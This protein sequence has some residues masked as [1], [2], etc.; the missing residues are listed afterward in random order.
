MDQPFWCDKKIVG[1]NALGVPGCGVPQPDLASALGGKPS[2]FV[3]S[4]N[5][6]WRFLFCPS[7]GRCPEGFEQPAF[8]DENFDTIP[9]PSDWQLE[10][11]DTPIY[12]NIR[13]PFPISTDKKEL[14]K[15]DPARNP[16]GI[17][18][19]R[20]SLP[21]GFAGR[22]IFLQLDGANSAAEVF[23]NGQRAGFCLSSFDPHRFDLTDLVREGENLLA[24]R[25]FRWSTGSYLEDQDMWRL[26]GLFR[27]VLL[28]AEPQTGMRDLT[29][30]TLF[31][32]G[33]DRATLALTVALPDQLPSGCSLQLA[34]FAPDGT[35]AL[36]QTLRPSGGVQEF[37]FDLDRPLLWSDE[38]PHLYR[39]ALAL[40]RGEKILD[41][42]GLSVGFREVR[43]EGEKLLLNG[44]PIEL[45]GVNR[46]E[47]HPSCGHAVS[48]AL[49]EADIRLLKQNNFNALRTS[50]YPN[51]DPVYELCD[52]YGILVMS[53]CNLETHGLAKQLPGSDP[54]WTAHGLDRMEKMV[55]RLRNHPCI[56][57]WSLGNESF[58]GDCFVRMRQRTL[59]LDDTRPIHY[60]PDN[61][62]VVS[63][64][65]S[66]MYATLDQVRRIGE[67][68][69][70]RLSRCSYGPAELLGRPA[71]VR[72]YGG[73]PYLLCEYA[74]CMGNSL[75]NF[76]DYWA[77]F[78]RYDRLIGGFIW[79]FADQA[80]KKGDRWC[81]G[82]DFGDQPND[83]PFAFNGLFRADR[84]PNPALQ[85][86]RQVLAPFALTLGE[87][88]VK[89]QSLL[90]FATADT[91]ALHWSLCDGGSPIEE[92]LL[93]VPPLAPGET[94][95]LTI[96]YNGRQS[97]QAVDLVCRLIDTAATP[98]APAGREICGS[99]LR[100]Q[101]AKV[102]MPARWVQV[103]Q[104]KK[105]LVLTSGRCTA[106]ILRRDGSLASYTVDGV[107][108]LAAPLRPQIARAVTDND[109]YLG[110]PPLLQ[111]LLR[112]GRW[113][114]ANRAIRP[115]HAAIE[116]DLLR[117]DYRAPGM[118]SLSVRYRM[119]ADGQL[120]LRFSA[121]CR[122]DRLPRA[123]VT[124]AAIP[125]MR[126]IRYFGRGPQENY[127]DRRAGALPGLYEFTAEN[128]GH[129][130][131]HPQ[132]NGNRTGVEL[133]RI[134][135]GGHALE[136][137]SCGAPFEAS[138]HPYSLAALE[139]AQHA[140]ELDLSGP[141]TVNLDAAQRGVGGD[142][143]AIA[144]TKRRY[145]I[146]KNRPYTLHLLLRGE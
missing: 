21:A 142:M 117:F 12:T 71:T 73:R 57:I 40:R 112:P 101:P 59:E 146:H 131:L 85:E 104:Q 133:L 24:I 50:H 107:E 83:G 88:G 25:V 99:A 97:A 111:K 1:Q 36:E 75:G 7:V 53:E 116:G 110:L 94:V 66:Q 69:P 68:K 3:L 91:L 79:D 122:S 45:R 132:E 63:D 56:L 58:T 19:R 115:V 125:E 113:L 95:Q 37:A 22:R 140:D 119:S 29:V 2:P 137:T 60:E 27:D 76:A 13:Y 52:R 127:V 138:A 51:S 128:F 130:Y 5:G 49:N 129:D 74:H 109:R 98:F 10:G 100:L 87:D 4:L 120:E 82:G 67:G 16:V 30:R 54:D 43:I 55:V 26:S 32:D 135:G 134:Y 18:R 86:A 139:A 136:I 89:I 123:G 90:R 14:P 47:F 102:T 20:F 145:R 72:Q 124:F 28:V 34:L 106:K 81:Y 17:Y 121:V 41:A 105:E 103:E 35:C 33:Y 93:R 84:S 48:A 15:I 6:S 46:H 39:L 62:F 77:L 23:C 126:S 118:K 8:P 9:V 44:R 38:L 70:V 96:E 31:P 78:R 92:G 108:L 65:F 144:L 42:R 114:R 141:L 61:R 11:Y 64:F 80:L 143:P